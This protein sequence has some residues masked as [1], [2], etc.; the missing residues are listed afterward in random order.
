MSCLQT[1]LFRPEAVNPSETVSI[2]DFGAT[3]LKMAEP[4]GVDA[5]A[6]GSLPEGFPASVERQA[7]VHP[8]LG[9]QRV[10]G[11]FSSTTHVFVKGPDDQISH[12]DCK[13]AVRREAAIAPLG[14][15]LAFLIAPGETRRQGAIFFGCHSPED[16]TTRRTLA[17]MA[18]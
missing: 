11:Q 1:G 16:A 2:A 12:I 9:A 17:L 3:V 15:G 6:I 4:F 7:P 18:N 14:P 13:N 8:C 10:F 5:V